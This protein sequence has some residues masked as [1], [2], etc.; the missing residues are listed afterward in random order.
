MY[1]TV[2]VNYSPKAKEMAVRVEETAKWNGQGLNW[3][4][5][6]LCPLPKVSWYLEN[7]VNRHRKSEP[8]SL[9]KA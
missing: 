3:F 4:P 6:L 9:Q 8:F 7:P 2:V 5:A 1:K